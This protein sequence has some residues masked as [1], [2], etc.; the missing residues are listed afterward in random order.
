MP[1]LLTKA[2]LVVIDANKTGRV[3]LPILRYACCVGYSGRTEL[4]A[5]DVNKT[6]LV[7]IDA[8]KN[9]SAVIHP[10]KTAAC[11]DRRKQKTVRPE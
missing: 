11:G 2:R 3:V 9:G 8:D 1:R 5:I 6:G 7:V 4:T 10:N